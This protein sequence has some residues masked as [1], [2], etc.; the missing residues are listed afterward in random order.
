METNEINLNFKRT[1][2]PVRSDLE[3]YNSENRI[4][5][6]IKINSLGNRPT[7]IYCE[8][9]DGGN[10]IEFWFEKVTRRLY[11]VTIVSVQEN[12]VKI[13]Y[14]ECF[15][16]EEYYD[17]YIDESSNTMISK[18]VQIL[19]EETSLSFYW[20]A[21][22]IYCYQ[23]AKNCVFGVDSKNNLCSINLINL[24]KELI[25]EGLGF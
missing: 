22:P 14:N 3:V 18:S 9:S 21:K 13:G 2:D 25:Y 24:S 20:G 6:S 4:P 17:C 11:E 16:N 19:R 7:S 10:F 23:I 8:L 12:L 5:F 1:L 15:F